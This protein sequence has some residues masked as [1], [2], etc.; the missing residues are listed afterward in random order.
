MSKRTS[1]YS[2]I[3]SENKEIKESQ[4]E[5]NEVNVDAEL[6]KKSNFLD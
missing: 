1:N 4:I 5:N 6:F 3:K 2:Y